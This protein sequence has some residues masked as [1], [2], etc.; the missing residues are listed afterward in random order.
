MDRIGG[1]GAGLRVVFDGPDGLALGCAQIERSL[2]A[3]QRSIVVDSGH[4]WFLG[5]RLADCRAKRRGEAKREL[6]AALET[7]ERLSAR[8]WVESARSELALAGHE[9][10]E[11]RP[12][13]F[14]SVL[15]PQELRVALVVA[16]GVTNREVAAQ[17][18]LSVKTI[19]NHLSHVFEKLGIRS[20]AELARIVALD[21]G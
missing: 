13:S 17:L 18:F 5:G 15:T 11:A 10:R 4:L 1:P 12:D 14:E 19:E 8:P 7:F 3:Q 9:K 21:R 16:T 2:A 6:E 20:R